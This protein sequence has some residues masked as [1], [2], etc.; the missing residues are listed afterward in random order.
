VTRP[1]ILDVSLRSWSPGPH[2]PE[3]ASCPRSSAKGFVPIVYGLLT[4]EGM[5]EAKAGKIACGGCTLDLDGP[6][7]CCKRCGHRWPKEGSLPTQE[8]HLAWRFRWEA[9]TWPARS[10]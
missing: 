9:K 2:L 8:E 1:I 3:P 4:E 10:A 6:R 7:W 5:A